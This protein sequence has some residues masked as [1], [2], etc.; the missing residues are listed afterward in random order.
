MLQRMLSIAVNGFI[1]VMTAVALVMTITGWG[2]GPDPGVLTIGP[3]WGNLRYFTV[4]SNI[5]S[6]V[7]SAIYLACVLRAGGLHAGVP[8]AGGQGVS[9]AVSVLKL[10][11][12]V[13]VTLTFLTVVVLFKAMW[14]IE[15][16]FR[17]PNLWFHLVLP[18]AAIACFCFLDVDA[19]VRLRDAFAAT[20]PMVLYSIGYYANI[21]VNGL[22]TPPHSNDWYGFASWG[23]EWA[24]VVFAVMFAATLLPA[25]CLVGLH[26]LCAQGRG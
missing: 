7:A 20:I 16:L 6:G 19:H 25:L 13:S 9:S 26:R 1:V 23:L 24:P 10:A 5:L 12:T 4:L 14:G 2:I 3:G 22:G 17:G 15:G 21:L 11:G 18:L 8:A